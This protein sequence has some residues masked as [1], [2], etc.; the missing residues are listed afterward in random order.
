MSWL[1]NAMQKALSCM[2][3][4]TDIREKRQK[5]VWKILTCGCG[6]G[7][8]KLSWLIKWEQWCNTGKNERSVIKTIRNRKVIWLGHTEKWLHSEKYNRSED[9]RK[10]KQRRRFWMLEDPQDGAKLF[11]IPLVKPFFKEIQNWLWKWFNFWNNYHSI[12]K[13]ETIPTVL[14]FSLNYHYI[15]PSTHWSFN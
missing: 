7:S 14:N 5:G 4:G 12:K 9:T 15:S 11:L 6:D 10:T 3:T 2:D 8:K 13:N 1:Q